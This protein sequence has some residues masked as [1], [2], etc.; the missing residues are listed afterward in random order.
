VCIVGRPNVGKSTLVNQIVGSHVAITSDRPQTTRNA[1]RGVLTTT[2]AQVVFVDTPGFHK[3][4]TALGRKLN[5]VVLSTLREVDL[6]LFCVDASEGVGRGDEFIAGELAKVQTPVICVLNKADLTDPPR[7]LAQVEAA[8]RFGDFADFYAV[9]ALTGNTVPD[10]VE[11]VTALMP[12][13]PV[14]YPPDQVTDQPEAVLVAELVREKALRLTREEIPHSIAVVVEEMRSDPETD[15]LEIDVI[16]YVERDSQ[17]G[18]VIGHKG[19]MLKQ[20]GTEARRDIEALLGTHVYLDLRVK[21]KKDWQRE[22][23]LIERFGYGS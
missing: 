10:L 6:I 21:V 2:E 14:W 13:G 20:V 23:G 5:S 7:L 19:Q 3:P 15:R 17:K 11:R 1:I 16:I 22:P 12:A 4:R 8:G 18:I 9:S